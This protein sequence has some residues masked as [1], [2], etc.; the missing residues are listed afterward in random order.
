MD[1][2]LYTIWT[3]LSLGISVLSM[4][5]DPERIS[6]RVSVSGGNH[7]DGAVFAEPQK[8]AGGQQ[9]FRAA[10]FGAKLLVFLDVWELSEFRLNRLVAQEGAPFHILDN[11]RM[12]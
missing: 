5:A 11:A 1:S 12:R 6:T 3:A 10:V 8:H 4:M 9:D 7:A 2:F